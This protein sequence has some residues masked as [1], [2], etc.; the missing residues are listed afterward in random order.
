M[1]SVSDIDIFQLFV[2]KQGKSIVLMIWYM[3]MFEFHIT[4][5]KQQRIRFT[6]Q[7]P[8]QTILSEYKS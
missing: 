2:G 4:R 8:I 5:I 3:S 6:Q 7:I 1:L